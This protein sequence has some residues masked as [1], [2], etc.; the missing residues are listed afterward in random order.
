MLGGH[1]SDLEAG[2]VFEPVEHVLTA[3]MASE[4]CRPSSPT[5]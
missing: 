4:A 5:A 2:D 1:I 3:L